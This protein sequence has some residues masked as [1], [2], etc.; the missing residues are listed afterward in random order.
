MSFLHS[1]IAHPN[2]PLRSKPFPQAPFSV[3]AKRPFLK[4]IASIKRWYR[5]ER[6]LDPEEFYQENV[7]AIYLGMYVEMLVGVTVGLGSILW[8]GIPALI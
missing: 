8:L 1:A 7:N 4:K 6:K 5:K 2:L 3:E